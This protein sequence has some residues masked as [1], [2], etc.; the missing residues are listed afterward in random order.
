MVRCRDVSSSRSI[1]PPPLNWASADSSFL[2]KRVPV[3][4][5][6]IPSC[7]V[8]CRAVLLQC[9]RGIRWRN[10]S[11]FVYVK[12]RTVASRLKLVRNK[13]HEMEL[14]LFSSDLSYELGYHRFPGNR[15]EH[16][17]LCSSFRSFY[18]HV[19]STVF[20]IG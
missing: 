12:I 16:V 11:C 8:P 18:M 10:Q 1:T 17:L 9:K 15:I 3:P 6:A 20:T 2:C 7:A 14:I 13:L 4:C 5:R 19:V